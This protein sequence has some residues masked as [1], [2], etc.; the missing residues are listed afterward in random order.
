VF[1][2]VIRCGVRGWTDGKEEIISSKRIFGNCLS[3]RVKR[4]I[5]DLIVN[6]YVG[7]IVRFHFA[8]GFCVGA[9]VNV[10]RMFV[11]C[12]CEFSFLL[13]VCWCEFSFLLN[14]CRCAVGPC[15]SKMV[16]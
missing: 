15:C 9:A 8:G 3:W 2:V 13:N 7:E 1:D 5:Q 16:A 12:W 10:R 11:S 14:V 4:R 6:G